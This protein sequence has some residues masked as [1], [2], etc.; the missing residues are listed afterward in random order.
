MHAATVIRALVV[1]EILLLIASVLTALLPNETP[2]ALA[3]YLEGPGAG[4]L[5]RLVDA[6]P[7]AVTYLLGALLAAFVAISRGG[8]PTNRWE[9][10]RENK[11]PG[12]RSSVRAAQLDR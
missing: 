5:F 2:L 6:G 7:T 1:T 4:P 10:T 9:R 8:H 3:E 11:V 12:A